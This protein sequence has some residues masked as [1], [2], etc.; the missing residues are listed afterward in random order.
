MSTE[1]NKVIVRRFFEAF[2]ANDQAALKDVLASDLVAYSHAAPGPHNREVH[3]QG[4]S[5][6]NAAFETHFTID[7]QIAE[8][9][10]VATR[11]T[12]RAIHNGGEFQGLPPTGKQVEIGG[13]TIERIKDGKIVERRVSSD[14]YG[15][16]QQLGLIPAPAPA[17]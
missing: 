3:L 16:M 17:G 6:W 5:M 15:L 8:G 9:D 12:M 7:E 13:T 1:Q 4:I 14:W 10:K 11:V 2:N